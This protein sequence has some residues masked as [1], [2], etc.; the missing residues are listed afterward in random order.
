VPADVARDL[1]ASGRVAD[2]DRVLQ[3][4]L[5]DEL[6]DVVCRDGSLVLA[7]AI[8]LMVRTLSRRS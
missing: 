4:E 3:V 2:V 8:G 6:G 1:A 5:L 7:F